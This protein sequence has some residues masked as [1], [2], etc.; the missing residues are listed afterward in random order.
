[1]FSILHDISMPLHS[2]IPVYAGDTPIVVEPHLTIAE[3]GVNVSA[4]RNATTHFGTHVDL[5]LH[6]IAGGADLDQ[7]SL[8]RF[9]GRARVI[10][11]ENR[12]AVTL[13]ELADHAIDPGDIV[14][15]RTRNTTDDLLARSAFQENY[16]YL[17]REAAQYLVQRKV[18]LVG[19]DY[20]SVDPPGDPTLPAH[21][22]LLGNGV[23]IL[24]GVVLNDVAPGIY[25]L[26]C[27]PLRI[28]CADGAP[29]RA[30][31]CPA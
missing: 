25:Q 22:I 28:R 24:E 19:I 12:V 11:I 27:L 5:P 30:V 2:Q 1:M 16:V 26:I 4:I 18:P 8:D 3:D 10:Q 29:A 7:V 23:L 14:I 17:Q 15:V 13:E 9:C 20:L 21:R 6:V 31:L